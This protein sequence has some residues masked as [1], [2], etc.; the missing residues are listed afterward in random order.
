MIIIVNCICLGT[1]DLHSFSWN[2]HINNP[3]IFDTLLARNGG[4]IEE[5]GS[6]FRVYQRQGFCM[7]GE[8]FGVSQ[9]TSLS[10]EDYS[11]ENVFEVEAKFFEGLKGTHTYSFKQGLMVIDFSKTENCS[12]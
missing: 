9:I 3:I 5:N 8:A 6:L 2:S 10:Q 7:Y 1:S 11:E 4:L 12:N